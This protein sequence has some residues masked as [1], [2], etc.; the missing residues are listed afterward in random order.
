MKKFLK[1]IVPILLA[2]V[3]VLCLIWYLFVYDRAFTRDILLYSAR[4]FD[5]NNKPGVAAWF[6]D[7]A[8]NQS[9]DSDEVAI[10]LAQQ[11]KLDGNF[12]QAEVIL[13]KALEENAST[14]L[15]TAL[16]RT[17]VEQDKILDAVK[18]LGGITNADILAEM[19]TLRPAVPTVSPDPGLYNQY[20]PVTVSAES[21][22][23]FVG[24]G[25]YPSIMD[26][27]CTDPITLTDG[28]N[29]LYAVVVADNG[30]VSPLS[31]FHYTVGGIIEEVTFADSAVE[32]S[33]REILGVSDDVVLMSNQIWELTSFTMPVEAMS[34][35]DLK[36]MPFLQELTVVNGPSNQLSIL[37]NLTNLNSLTI[38]NTPVNESELSIIG[39]LPSL[40]N[41]TLNNCG[42]ST[43]GPI[44][45]LTGLTYL[46]L[47]N[48]AIRN[49]GPLSS[50]T[51]LTELRLQHN[52]LTDLGSLTTLKNLTRLDVSYNSLSTLT[53]ICNLT[54]L[55]W[56]DANHNS[57]IEVEN[58]GNLTALQELNLSY[59]SLT[60]AASLA[61]CTA[62]TELNL[63]N[64]ALTDITAA[65][66]LMNMVKLDFSYNQVT[67]L[68]AF[69]VDCALVTIDGSHNL[70]E[71]LEPLAGLNALNGV[72]MDYNEKV[73]SIESLGTCPTLIIVNVYG[74]AVTEVKSLTDQSIIV[75]F[76]P[77]QSDSLL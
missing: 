73:E 68:P 48:N 58:I 41:L 22:K 59:N 32:R 57:L 13:S 50:L 67:Q 23:L 18:L 62:L 17:Y 53:P 44:E 27:P 34:F 45:K 72:Y 20:I 8:Y 66:S 7:L 16:S 1:F 47:G 77:T 64:N 65:A 75:N 6:Y 21:G 35:A 38:Q 36:Y 49:I 71:D 46:D 31:T 52:V 70:L 76:N 2:I 51:G 14:A 15:Y 40:K 39:S 74:T 54:G 69:S 30:L 43:A 37:S 42:L 5:S 63:S 3:I 61:A 11:H 33:V 60:D 28:E 9:V 26:K 25:E 29:I 55:V 24:I 19:E 4:Y 10:E 12:T 56:L